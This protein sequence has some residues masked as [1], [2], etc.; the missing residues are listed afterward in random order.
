MDPFRPMVVNPKVL[1][2]GRRYSLLQVAGT[3]LISHNDDPRV[4]VQSF[5]PDARTQALRRY[6]HLEGGNGSRA[7]WSR[8]GHPRAWV[9]RALPT[10]SQAGS[11]APVPGP[12]PKPI[13]ASIVNSPW[14]T[15]HI[16]TP[17]VRSLKS[18]GRQVR[19]RRGFAPAARGIAAAFA[20]VGARVRRGI[21]RPVRWTATL[22]ADVEARAT[23]ERRQRGSGQ[24]V[25]GPSRRRLRWVS[26]LA[27]VGGVVAIAL[28]AFAL[29]RPQTATPVP[30]QGNELR[31][32]V[33][34]GD[35]GQAPQD[36]ET[37]VGGVTA[38]HQGE[39]QGDGRHAGDGTAGSD[40]TT[41]ASGSDTSGV[42]TVSGTGSG[43]GSGG[44]ASGSSTGSSGSGSTGDGSSDGSGDG[45][46][47]GSGSGP[48]GAGPGSGSGGGGGGGD[49]GGGGGGGGGG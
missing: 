49:G 14:R 31:S 39:D 42:Q 1:E 3:Y 4:P 22:F 6:R 24:A 9:L 29:T 11:D 32:P 25:D 23:G 8:L 2:Q 47:T 21:A 43:S 26:T 30:T 33:P 19:V 45:S 12:S 28:I 34:V 27:S 41:A 7:R 40:S 10:R 20:S 15:R 48:G 38:T 18:P 37:Q 5:P 16:S 46:S 35:A 36:V 44:S 13:R 17:T